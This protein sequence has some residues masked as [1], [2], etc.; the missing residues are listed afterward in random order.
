MMLAY[1]DC[2]SGISGDMTLGALVDLGVPLT[3][4]KEKIAHMP[5]EGFDIQAEAVTRNGIQATKVNVVVQE[6]HH[7]RDYRDIKKLISES[8][9]PEKVKAG[10]LGIFNAIATAEAKIH[11]CAKEDVH[12]HEVGSMDAIVDVVG[13]CLAM[14]YLKVDKIMASPL[15]LGSGFVNCQH[16]VLPV[17]APATLEILK[18]VPVYGGAAQ[19]E[20]VTPTGAGIA[21]GLADSFESLPGMQIEQIGYGAGTRELEGQPNLLRIVLG[22]FTDQKA[23]MPWDRLVM[24]ECCLDDMNPEW[25]GYLMDKLFMDGVLDVYWVPV[26]MKKNRPGTMVQ[27]LCE[28]EKRESVVGRILSET[29]TL[30][31]RFYDVYRT[32]LERRKVRVQ[33]VFGA[34]EVKEV[35]GPD[36]VFRIIPE[37]EV[38][39]EI[40]EDQ[41]MSLRKVYETIIRTAGESR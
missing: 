23:S 21:T 19:Q 18:G 29:T 30:G 28:P 34:I 3:W 14:S 35:K 9:L 11:S 31:V 27:V 15:P 1:L 37:F 2:F 10:S 6:T 4:L 32:A 17:P 5:L 36:G 8:T 33:T 20:L 16:G 12:F 22:N 39:R 41:G 38:C 13:T 40:A 26:F 24:V 25:F 7:H